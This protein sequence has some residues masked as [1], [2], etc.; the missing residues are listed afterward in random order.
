MSTPPG[1]GI[2]VR[3]RVKHYG[4]AAVVRDIDLEIPRAMSDPNAFDWRVESV[5]D[6]TYCYAA[7]VGPL[8]TFLEDYLDIALIQR[9][10]PGR[11]VRET[12]R[13]EAA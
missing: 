13:E 4:R 5:G 10:A 6:T 12:D 7:D 9:P 8:L 1:S 3:G 11:R 2:A